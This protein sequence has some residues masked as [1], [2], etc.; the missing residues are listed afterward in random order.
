MENEQGSRTTQ[1]LKQ[2]SV[3]ETLTQCFHCGDNLPDDN[4]TVDEKLFCCTGCKTVYQILS[5]HNLCDYYAHANKPGISQRIAVRKEKFSFLDDETIAAKLI[6]FE[7]EG[8]VQVCF[9]LPQIHCSSCLW[10]LE[11][12]NELNSGIA[13]SRVDFTKKEITVSFNKQIVSLRKV[14]ETIASIGYEPHISLNDLG[15]KTKLRHYDRKRIYRLGIAGFCFSN[16]MMLSFPE[17]FGLKGIRNEMYVSAAFQYI[18]V[19]LSLPVFFYS[20][21]EFFISGWQGLR[22][23]FLNIDAPIAL[24]VLITFCR[25]LYEIFTG[26]GSGYLDSMSGIVFF[27]L[28]GRALQDRTRKSLSFDRD[29]TSYFPI[30]VSKLVGGVEMPAAL[31]DLRSGDSIIIHSNEIIPADGLLVRGNASID[32]SFVTGESVPVQKQVSEICY[33]GGKQLAGNIE[34]LLVKDVSQ[35]YLTGLWNK[36]SMRKED[37]NHDSF[38]H[39]LSQYFTIVLF[40]IAAATACWWA[41]HDESKIWPA[42]TAILIVACPCALL[43]GNSFTNSHII[44]LFDNAGLY[45]RNAAVVERMCRITHIV[46]DKTGTLTNAHNIAVTQHGDTLNTAQKLL[47]ASLAAQSNHP[48][49]KAIAAFLNVG[50]IQ[51]DSVKETA[52][53]GCEAWHN[54]AHIV[55]GSP[56]FVWQR[57]V[58]FE[59]KTVVAFRIDDVVVGWFV[60]A[61]QYRK[62]LSEM[63][64]RISKKYGLSVISGD[65]DGAKESLEKLT[66]KAAHLLF[67][68]H[69]ADKLL[70]TESLEKQDENVLMVGDGLNDAGALKQSLVGIAVTE[71]INNFS[72]ACDAVLQADRLPYL[73][74]Y[75]QLAIAGKHIVLTS[76]II[77][78]CY[79]IVGL[80]YAVQAEL[81]PLVAAILMPASSIS[82]VFFTW[83]AVQLAGRKWQKLKHSKVDC[84]AII[85]KA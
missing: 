69:P 73:Y 51:L 42:V 44:R 76:F 72:P 56:E 65:N 6:Q 10:L 39:K 50:S 81:S 66:N 3:D 54:D 68:Q 11:H 5:T 14:A 75:L 25:S 48:L 43:L 26:A 30:A 2:K 55:L 29:Y 64:T 20:A 16:I 83:L 82:I 79:N 34:L 37:S 41:F 22:H 15:G 36:E 74:Q 52:G 84:D 28:A 27:M 38:V 49:S 21:G 60:I 18:I 1:Q 47:I 23:R 24:A 9:Y 85:E 8:Q 33:A 40:S 46:F 70:Y 78:V 31:P 13:G 62:G 19:L 67:N 17:Y 77:S 59:G 32:Y 71:D 45:V 7:Q 63:F 57:K 80:T 61:H 4:I 58:L 12:L 35:S 53:E